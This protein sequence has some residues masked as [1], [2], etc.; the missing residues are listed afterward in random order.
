[1]CIRDRA[2]DAL[3]H[4]GLLH[5]A[6]ANA[7]DQAGLVL[8]ELLEPGHVSQGA[9]LGIVAHAAGIEDDQVRLCLLYTSFR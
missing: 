9:A 3:G 4:A 7:D 8:F 5:H 6:A 2:Q 1:M